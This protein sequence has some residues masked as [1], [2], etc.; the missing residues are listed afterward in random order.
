MTVVNG[1]YG[2]L[3]VFEDFLSPGAANAAW[4]DTGVGIL[5]DICYTSV[6]EGSFAPTVDEPGGI[7]AVTTDTADNDNWAGFVG[8]FKP[9]DGGCWMETRFKVASP[10]TC[11]IYA[12]FTETL[13]LDTPV[14]PAEYATATLTCN[15]SGGMVGML[16]DA[17]ATTDLWMAVAGDGGA[18]ETV[19]SHTVGP[20]ADYWDIVRVEIDNDGNGT[21]YINGVKLHTFTSCVTSTDIQHAVLLVENRSGAANTLEIDYFAAGGG[22]DWTTS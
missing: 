16:H 5:G 4:S 11:A 17:D 7:V 19:Y 14:C 3:K 1:S 18:E 20:T 9:A 12:G 13:A 21:C 22:R 2:K 15:G 10:T 6:N 8:V